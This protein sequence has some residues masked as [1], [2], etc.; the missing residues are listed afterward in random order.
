MKLIGVLLSGSFVVGVAALSGASGPAVASRLGNEFT[1]TLT[2]GG[3][4]VA[5]NSGWT[6]PV[7]CTSPVARFSYNAHFEYNEVAAAPGPH[8]P[9]SHHWTVT[10]VAGPPI[11]EY[12]GCSEEDSQCDLVIDTTSNGNTVADVRLELRNEYNSLMGA[13]FVRVVG[14]CTTVKPPDHPTLC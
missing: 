12:I 2:V 13:Y 9:Y 1:C 11:A 6:T 10:S 5:E 3:A 4:L 8:V 14:P 7:V